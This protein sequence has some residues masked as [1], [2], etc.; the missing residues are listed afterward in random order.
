MKLFSAV[1]DEFVVAVPRTK[2]LPVPLSGQCTSKETNLLPR[3]WFEAF[4]TSAYRYTISSW[5]KLLLGLS[6]PCPPC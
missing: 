5:E 3:R 6:F 1:P 2:M 4:L